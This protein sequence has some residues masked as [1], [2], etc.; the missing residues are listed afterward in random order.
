MKEVKVSVI[1]PVYNAE[2][3]IEQCL[4]SI[5]NQTLREIEILLVDDSSTDSSLSILQEYAKNDSRIVVIENIHTGEGAA[6]AR[7][8]GLKK[9]TGNYLSI[10]DADDF[11]ELDMLEKAY[12]KATATDAD[13]VLYDGKFYD[14]NTKQIV[15]TTMI[16]DRSKLPEQAV[17]SYKEIPDSIFLCGAPAAWSKLF[18]RQLIAQEQLQFQPIYYTDDVLFVLSALATAKKIT[19]LKE[20]LIYYRTNQTEAQAANKAKSPLSIAEACLAL[21]QF[22]KEKGLFHELQNAYA[23]YAIKDIAFCLNTL[24]TTESFSI[25]YHALQE[26][27]LDELE[28][29][30]S[31]T[32][33]MLSFDAF[34]WIETIKKSDA[35]A[36]GFHV[37]GSFSNDLFFRYGTARLFPMELMPK[38]SK[39]ILYGAGK[40]GNSLY[41]QNILCNHCEI[42]AWVDKF[43]EGKPFPIEGLS[44]LEEKKNAFDFV[45]VAIENE[46]TA[47]KVESYLLQIGIEK[48]SI[49]LYK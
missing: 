31:L 14:E 24:A 19:V 45:L 44:I 21:K 4:E 42:L 32:K 35:L 16:L 25:L 22:L 1:V 17:F 15:D 37:D 49:L 34:Q 6:S 20:N 36:Y 41:I 48:E 39:I 10:V 23:N 29:V 38:H 43:P 3:Y 5:C 27:Y 30:T 46:D 2:K 8:A 9:A 11:F 7:N 28:L 40:V 13:V 12:E 26:K 47:K 33:N 18:K